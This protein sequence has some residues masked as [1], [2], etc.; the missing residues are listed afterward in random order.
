[1]ARPLSRQSSFHSTRSSV[2][3]AVEWGGAEASEPVQ[4][5]L[6]QIIRSNEI[7]QRENEL[8]TNYLTRYA[9]HLLAQV[10]EEE[11]KGR[12]K[13][14]RK[15]VKTAALTW[16]QKLEIATREMEE[17]RDEIEKTKESSERLLDNLRA[18]IEET[19]ITITEIKK[20]SYEFRRDL[21]IVTESGEIE[22]PIAEKV[23]RYMEDQLKA[24]D[25]LVE[26]LRLKN[27]T[28]KTQIQKMETQ[29]QQK[30]EMGEVLHA[31][32]FEQLKIEN[33]QYL[34]KIEER[35]SELLR[36]KLTA[37][38]TVQVL[39]NYKKKLGNL[40]TEQ[41]WLKKEIESRKESLAKLEEEIRKVS[42]ER[43]Q[44]AR[45]N[46]RLRTQ[47]EEYKVPMVLDYVQQK[48]QM[49]ELE[50][51]MKDWVRKVDIAEMELKRYRQK[52]RSAQK[53]DLDYHVNS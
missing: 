4:S 24:K 18:M 38:N 23:V 27:A 8:Y 51:K 35:N 20:D 47:Q 17:V 50:K 37:G 31:I 44:A 1:M 30:E 29:L 45:V 33:Q 22:N 49:Y 48:A 42:E 32:D 39:N 9:P 46:T 40:T 52:A 14:R 21:E 26:K 25:A 5:R 12:K 6:E 19:E 10:D 28:L 2:S 53:L 11:T 13:N 3:A 16:E 15:E 7:L 34:E 41:Q 36:L 43:E